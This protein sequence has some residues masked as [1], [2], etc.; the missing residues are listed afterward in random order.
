V[1]HKMFGDE[2]PDIAWTLNNLSAVLRQESKLSEAEQA[3]YQALTMRKKLL[4][5]DD[6]DVADSIFRGWRLC[7]G[8]PANQRRLKPCF[9]RR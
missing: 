4:R 2:H 5:E 3:A 7:S 8:T 9:A 1:T 6:P